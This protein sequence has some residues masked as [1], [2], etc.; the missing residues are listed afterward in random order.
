MYSERLIKADDPPGLRRYLATQLRRD[1]ECLRKGAQHLRVLAWLLFIP[2]SFLSFVL[3]IYMLMRPQ[4]NNIALFLVMLV[5]LGVS[6]FYF[7]VSTYIKRARRWA[8]N[9]AL[10]VAMLPI[11]VSILLASQPE[12]GLHKRT[13][14]NLMVEGLYCLLHLRMILDLVRCLGAVQRISEAAQQRYGTVP[15]KTN[16]PWERTE[17]PR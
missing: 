17:A 7:S 2:T 4:M 5:L 16:E 13:V 6:A 14:P 8:V 10:G 9:V 12:V 1:L 15:V 3:F 11:V